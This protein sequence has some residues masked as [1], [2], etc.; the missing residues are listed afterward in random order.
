MEEKIVYSDIFRAAWKGLKSQFWLLVGLLI[1]FTI[2]YSLLYL[3]A[4]PAKGETMSISGIIVFILCIFLYYLFIMGYL[5]NCLQTLDGEEPQFSAYGQVTRKL[6]AFILA[7]ILY[8]VIIS[9]GFALLIIPGIY[10]LLRLQFFYASMVD[11]NTGIV[12][13]FKRSWNITKGYSLQLFILMLIMILISFIGTIALFIGIFVAVPL[14]TLIYGYT[15]RKLT[16][17]AV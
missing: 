14:T 12:E 5:K 7:S 1:G 13:S 9:I 10:L 6:P 16:A 8:S 17:P 3:F 2:I 15:Y 11:E 4:I